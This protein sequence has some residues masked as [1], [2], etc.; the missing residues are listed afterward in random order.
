M[1]KTMLAAALVCAGAMGA[2][3]EG[4]FPELS[5]DLMTPEQREQETRLRQQVEQQHL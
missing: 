2:R 4:R 5:L 1:R 3:A